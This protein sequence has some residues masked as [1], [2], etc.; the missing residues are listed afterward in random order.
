MQRAIVR[1]HRDVRAA[2]GADTR[3][4]ASY[5]DATTFRSPRSRHQ[6]GPKAIGDLA[7]VIPPD[8]HAV[9]VGRIADYHA[10]RSAPAQ[11]HSGA[12]E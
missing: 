3:P 5:A 2:V 12:E 7:R 4:P 10:G 1:E 11:P 6:I 8:A 9:D